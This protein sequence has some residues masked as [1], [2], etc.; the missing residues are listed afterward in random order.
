LQSLNALLNN[1]QSM[2]I[3]NT[4]TIWIVSSN[5]LTGGVFRT[6]NGGANW[7]PQGSFG[8]NNPAHIYMFNARLGFIDAGSLRKTTDGGTTWTPI[9][10]AGNFLDMF[11]IDSLTGWKCNLDMKKTTDGGFNWVTQIIP[12]G[13]NILGQG[14][15]KFLNIDNDTIWV[16][17]DC[18]I[19]GGNPVTRGILFRTTNGGSNWLFQV[20]DTSI[21]IVEY[22]FGKFFN[23]KYGWAYHYTQG[24]IHTTTGGEGIWYTDVKQVHTAIPDKNVLYQNY[25]NPFNPKT[26]IIY[27]LKSRAKIQLRVYDLTGKIISTLVDD[28]QSAGIHKEEFRSHNLSSGI[29]FYSL[30]TDGNII[31]TKKMILVK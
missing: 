4:D 13:G 16:V 22:Y 25:P 15:V 14:A 18:I 8:S 9:I 30:I 19:T 24:G 10:G 2:S 12:S 20:P 27:E 23:N 1:Y 28:E 29:Y 7:I 3:L 6:N 21:H 31:D 11:F 5:P 17:G 26:I